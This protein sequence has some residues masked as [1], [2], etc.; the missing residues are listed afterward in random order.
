MYCILVTGVPAAGKTTIAK[1]IG[2]RLGLPVFSK[3]K[4]KE[5][6]FDEVGFQSRAEKVKLGVASM[7]LMYYAAGQLMAAGQ[8]FILENNFE[9]SSQQGLEALL[10]KYQ[11]PVLTVTLTGDYRVIY[12]R[13]LERENS[14]DR[15]RGHVVNDCY[16]EKDGVRP[17]RQTSPS[18][19]YED[20][21]AGIEK[22][23]FAAFAVGG[24]KIRADTTDF[25][26]LDL[27]A[28]LA[29]IEAWKERIL[30]G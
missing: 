17:A 18:I 30:H 15:H 10:E 22:R 21:V 23:G 27:G 14:S 25:S 5:L 13:F 29:Q 20:Y 1:A 2:E 6:L 24:E 8:P 11:Y 28:L 3:D 16:P 7:E 4:I 19:S 9:Y 12:R 26:R